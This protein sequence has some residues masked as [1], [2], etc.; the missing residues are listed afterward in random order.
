MGLGSGLRFVRFSLVGWASGWFLE[1]RT[2][3][4]P[5]P[6]FGFCVVVKVRAQMPTVLFGV[7]WQAERDTALDL[8]EQESKAPP[9]LRSVGALQ[10]IAGLRQNP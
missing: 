1:D 8:P 4:K 7:R 3:R 9:P 10:I 5:D 6:G 2:N